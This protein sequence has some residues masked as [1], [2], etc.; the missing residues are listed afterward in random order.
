MSDEC[1]FFALLRKRLL[2]EPSGAMSDE[3][4]VIAFK[5]LVSKQGG[6]MNA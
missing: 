6:A 2:S 3:C 1:S 4:S 5:R